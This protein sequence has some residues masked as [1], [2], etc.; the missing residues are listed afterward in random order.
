MKH[1]LVFFTAV[2]PAFVCAQHDHHVDDAAKTNHL[3]HM[4][5]GR[6]QNFYIHNLPA[7]KL[8]A[9]IGGSKMKIETKSQKTQAYFNQG[10][11]L[12]HDF[13]D[14]EAYRAFKEAIRND[15]TAVM[16]YWG[17]LQT[18]GPDEDSVYKSNKELAVKQ[19]KKLVL[20]ANEHEKS[21]A[22]ASL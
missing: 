9:N 14:F 1:C 13:W 22:E 3:A 12:L 2:L 8:M 19:L 20:T 11:S 16:P 17:L 6:A 7:P 10:L 5:A 21:Y 15:S 4:Q 18:L